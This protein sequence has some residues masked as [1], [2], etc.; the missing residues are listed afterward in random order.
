MVR[1]RSTG[2][3][4]TDERTLRNRRSG[5]QNHVH[6][7]TSPA[8]R[9]ASAQAT[10]RPIGPPQSWPARATRGGQVRAPARRPPLRARQACSRTREASQLGI[11]TTAV[12][13]FSLML[14]PSLVPRLVV[15]RRTG[16]A[17]GDV[18]AV[19]RRARPAFSP[20]PGRVLS[21]HRY[22]NRAADQPIRAL[23]ALLTIEDG[24]C[25]SRMARPEA[26]PRGRSEPVK[27]A[28]CRQAAR[29]LGRWFRDGRPP[30]ACVL[31]RPLDEDEQTALPAGGR[32]VEVEVRNRGLVGGFTLPGGSSRM[33]SDM[34]KGRII[35]G[36]G[37]CAGLL[38]ALAGSAQAD[39]HGDVVR[40][41]QPYPLADSTRSVVQGRQ[42]AVAARGSETRRPSCRL[43]R[44]SVSLARD[45]RAIESRQL[46]INLR[47]CRATFE[48]GVPP[49]W[50]EGSSPVR[51][52]SAG[53]DRG[54]GSRAAGV[55]AAARAYTFGGYSKAWYTDA[56][57]GRILNS[58]RSGADWNRSGGCVGANNVWFRTFADSFTGW[59]QVSRRWSYINTR[60]DY[61]VSSTNA[62]FR[63]RKFSGCSDGPV[64]DAHY[65]RVRFVGYPNGN[66][67]GYRRSW[68]EPSCYPVLV[69]HLALYRR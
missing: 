57:T 60:C 29:V 35:Q 47:T 9:P 18:R 15:L 67:K 17:A 42:V 20:Q 53:A 3:A 4:T 64:V 32:R 38:L 11:P 68:I 52:Q 36:L 58:V 48:R 44:A 2:G 10:E 55:R 25:R 33:R 7:S 12:S 59:S 56:R 69:A 40:F 41:Q 63:D 31:S 66:A 39:S 61:V 54:E 6:P 43:P 62:H 45:E 8:T 50:T 23:R 37:L 51:Q 49:K 1:H 21:G 22:G 5:G 14:V 30:A 34:T 19:S 27:S 28:R 13:V 16:H 26:A 65:S 46:S 24:P